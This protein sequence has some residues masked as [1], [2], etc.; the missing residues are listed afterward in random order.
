MALEKSLIE[1]MRV[2]TSKAALAA[3][4]FK[5]LNDKIAADKA[6]VDIMRAELNDLS[7]NGRVV[8]GEGELD[9]APMLYIGEKLGRKE[10]AEIDIAVDPVEGTNFVAKNLPGGISVLAIAEK[11]NLFHAPETYMDKIA[12]GKFIEKGTVDLDFT[13]EKN[14]KNLADALNKQLSDL[15]VC[16]LDRDRHKKIIDTLDNLKVKKKLITDG[17]VSGALYVTNKKFGVDMFIGIGGGPEGVLA[18]SALDAS[19]CFFQGR[20][21]FNEDHNIRRAKEMGIKDL[22]KKYQLNEIISGDSI[23]SATGITDGDLVKGIEIKGKEYFSETLVTH[24]NSNTF[25]IITKKEE[26]I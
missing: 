24:K 2:V 17:D 3:S 26:I 16:L 25:E 10:G 21:I 14:L 6:A 5:G 9:E 13:L 1:K 4:K 20:F 7:I 22:N 11:N 8:I 12:V 23:F 19:N 15:T 18:A